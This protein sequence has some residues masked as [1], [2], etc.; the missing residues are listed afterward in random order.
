MIILQQILCS[1]LLPV[2]NNAHRIRFVK[3]FLVGR[4]VKILQIQNLCTEIDHKFDTLH[5]CPATSLVWPTK[6][7][8]LSIVSC[9]AGQLTIYFISEFF[10]FF[11]FL[12][13]KN[14][15]VVF[16][17]VNYHPF[18]SDIPCQSQAMQLSSK[19]FLNV[20]TSG[21]QKKG[22]L[23]F[24]FFPL[25]FNLFTAFGL[26]NQKLVCTEVFQP[27][28]WF[29]FFFKGFCF[30]FKPSPFCS[31]CIS[32]FMRVRQTLQQQM[33]CSNPSINFGLIK[34]TIPSIFT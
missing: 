30:Q 14:D 28:N 20:F 8:H 5:M 23:F 29:F 6:I 21:L 25:Q 33:N 16:F 17:S 32:V 12:F 11:F 22:G 34:S 24:F 4:F 15:G 7:S 26:V 19:R 1:K 9:F 13:L 31:R 2:G 3:L 27:L 18:Q 10:F